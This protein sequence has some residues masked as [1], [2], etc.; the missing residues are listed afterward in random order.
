MPAKW[1]TFSSHFNNMLD[2]Y[3]TLLL[4]V[5][6]R[7]SLFPYLGFCHPC[8]P[9]GLLAPLADFIGLFIGIYSSVDPLSLLYVQRYA[10]WKQTQV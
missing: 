5:F 7:S 10:K 2:A 6:D 4:F 1:V 9:L 8:M 3:L